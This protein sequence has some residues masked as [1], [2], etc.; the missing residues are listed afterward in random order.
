MKAAHVSAVMILG[1]DLFFLSLWVTQQ[2]GGGKQVPEKGL[3]APWTG[4]DY[5]GKDQ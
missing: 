4:K 2:S 1:E 3:L 5:A